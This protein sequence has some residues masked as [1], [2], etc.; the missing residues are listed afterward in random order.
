MP[1]E[2]A[3][4]TWAAHTDTRDSIIAVRDQTK[5]GLAIRDQRQRLVVPRAEH[6]GAARAGITSQL[7]I[8]ARRIA[9]GR[10]GP[11][12]PRPLRD[13]TGGAGQRRQGVVIDA[14]GEPRGLAGDPRS[15]RRVGALTGRAAVARHAVLTRRAGLAEDRV[16]RR[17]HQLTRRQRREVARARAQA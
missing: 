13:L 15:R 9:I 2:S 4:L 7:P 14:I 3:A 5:A 10:A 1:R 17:R 16:R 8:E 12:G 6:P 11:R